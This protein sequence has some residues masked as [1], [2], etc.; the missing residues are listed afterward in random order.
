[1]R[2][3]ATIVATVFEGLSIVISHAN[4]SQV[5]T[6]QVDVLP[7]LLTIQFQYFSLKLPLKTTFLE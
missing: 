4:L 7:S 6:K 2:S 3:K 1:M 5:Y